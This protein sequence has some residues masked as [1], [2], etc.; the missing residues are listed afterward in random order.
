MFHG[1]TSLLSDYALVVSPSPG[2]PCQDNC[3]VLSDTQCLDISESGG[4]VQ[5]FRFNGA[6]QGSGSAEQATIS[7]N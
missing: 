1:D 4:K 5:S 7:L 3:R 6:S 2:C